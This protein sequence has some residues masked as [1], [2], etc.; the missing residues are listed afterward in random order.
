M[1]KV[2]VLAY[3]YPPLSLSGVQRTLKFTKYMSQFNWEPTVIT[4]GN[5]A[6]FA[7][8]LNMLKEAED[9]N[10]RII[11]TEAFDLNAIIGKKFE[12][13]TMPRE[14]V[15][16]TLSSIS[17]AVFI[18]DNKKS[19]AKKAYK[20]AAELLSK[21]K[22]DIIYTSV[23]PYSSFITAAKL[24]K[25][26]N[27]P[28]FVDYRDL[29][30]N[31]QFSF[32][33]T[34]YHRIKHKKLEYNSLRAADKVIT[35]NRKIKEKMLLTYPFLSYNDILI[36]PHGFDTEDFEKNTAIPRNSN[37]MRITY[38]G[39]FYDAI[40]PEYF[41][42]AFKKLSEER[43]DIAANIELE[44]IG[45][46]RKEYKKLIT[47]LGLGEYV[48]DNGYLEHD[49]VIKRLK[50]ADILW[51][52]IGK[53]KSGDTISTSKLYEY[54][55]TRKPILGCVPEG[56]AVYA[57]Q[58]YKASFIVD[59]YDIDAIKNELVKINELFRNNK[60]PVPPEDVVEK[61]DRKNLTEQLTKALQFFVQE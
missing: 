31:S 23:P 58:E 59:P 27:I 56:A 50:S 33:P 6:Y 34:P 3:Y 21:E 14:F 41:I 26:F 36:I 15:R 19:W 49:Q 60:L 57:L 8:D 39:I 32:Y 5:V 22:F 51:F 13:V 16:K 45:L 47:E 53:M 38:S 40:T 17:K 12:T 42:K 61:Y 2:L 1:F 28:L 30:F 25:E 52:M 48:I 9:A 43:P 29:W 46:L 18:P 55:G 44:F 7:H 37:K 35:I 20:V 4:T 54:I 10:V 11:R 24:K